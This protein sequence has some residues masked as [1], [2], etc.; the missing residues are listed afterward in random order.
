[1]M[2][3]M[4][5]M[6]KM[7]KSSKNISVLDVDTFGFYRPR[8]RQ[9]RQAYEA[10]LAIIQREFGDQPQNVICGAADEVLTVLK[11]EKLQV[12]KKIKIKIR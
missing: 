8:T 11:N 10:L 6:K 12:N 9:T 7:K 3:E 5:N 4:E 2:F 1:M